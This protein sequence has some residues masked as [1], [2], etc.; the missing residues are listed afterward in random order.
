[1]STDAGLVV[2]GSQS[3]VELIPKKETEEKG[4]C[5][6]KGAEISIVAE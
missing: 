3:L 2:F 5:E 1:M 6:G 4:E